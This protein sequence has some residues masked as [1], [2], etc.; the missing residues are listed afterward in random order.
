MPPGGCRMCMGMLCGP[1]A[2]AGTCTPFEKKL[3]A[4]EARARLLQQIG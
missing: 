3:E 4:I 1:C 2:D